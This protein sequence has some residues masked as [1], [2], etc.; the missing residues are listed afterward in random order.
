MFKYFKKLFD[1]QFY[2]ENKNNNLSIFIK[3]KK[4]EILKVV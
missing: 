3:F 2:K 1:M 4:I